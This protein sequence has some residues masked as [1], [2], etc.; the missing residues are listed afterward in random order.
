VSIAL[1]DPML[2]TYWTLREALA[3]ITRR[4]ANDVRECAVVSGDFGRW[5]RKIGVNYGKQAL[6]QA[7]TALRQAIENGALVVN[8]IVTAESKRRDIAPMECLDR[9]FEWRLELACFATGRVATPYIEPAIRDLRVRVADV[10]RMFPANVAVETVGSSQDGEIR[11]SE[12]PIAEASSPAMDPPMKEP[13]ASAPRRRGKRQATQLPHAVAALE[14]LYPSGGAPPPPNREAIRAAV[15]Q[16]MGRAVSM[17]T[18]DRA[19]AKLWPPA[20]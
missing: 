2:E 20:Q 16:K 1:Y 7:F 6:N 4:D 17:T 9:H 5:P 8:G 3:W 18:V 12:S 10:L 11:G 13:P 15:E 19:R 14:E